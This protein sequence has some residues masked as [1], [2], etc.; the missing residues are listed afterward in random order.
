MTQSRSTNSD[1]NG[2]LVPALVLFGGITLI[3][4]A[5]LAARPSP[6]VDET[7]AAA[8]PTASVAV[9]SEPTN[10]PQ[11]VA[12]AQPPDPARVN[13]G[14]NIFSGTCTACH[15]FNAMGIPG[16][17]KTLIG[18]EFVNSKTDDELVAFLEVGR[19]VTDPLN[20]TGV[21]MPP[22]GGNPTLS[23]DQLMDVVLYIRSLNTGS[24]ATTP[25][26]AVPTTSGEPVPTSEPAQFTPIDINALPVPT[27]I[28]S[29]VEPT[30]A[31]ASS[32]QTQSNIEGVAMPGQSLYDQN[33]AGCHGVRGEG[34][35]MVAKSLKESQ[36]F[37]EQNTMGL[38][39]FL[40]A[41]TVT[42]TGFPHPERGGNLSLADEDLLA[43]I[44][45][46]YSLP[47]E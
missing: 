22:K 4:I 26:T 18:S 19:Q 13:A 32:T 5:L 16:L 45:Y 11:T 36:M 20:T 23:N 37:N 6:P 17:G 44:A 35:E 8:P 42:A 21:M 24:A 34:V 31:E 7:V 2:V 43:I 14:A 10:A 25:P 46:M 39:S 30:P 9:S 3:L 28:S 40:Q 27:S 12:Q 29:P 33:C 41:A 15:G 1:T 47:G 38:L